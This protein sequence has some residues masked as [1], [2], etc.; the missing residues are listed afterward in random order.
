MDTLVHIKVGKPLKKRMQLLVNS[1]LFANTSEIVRQGLRDLL[2]NKI[3]KNH[4]K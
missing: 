1:G 3:E 4:R 2:P